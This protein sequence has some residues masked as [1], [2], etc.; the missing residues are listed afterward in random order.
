MLES[1]GD[2][3]WAMNQA[4]AKEKGQEWKKIW[5]FFKKKDQNKKKVASFLKRCEKRKVNRFLFTKFNQMSRVG[6]RPRG[7][8]M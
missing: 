1:R 8:H 5:S 2:D 7:Q 6:S 3:L 4:D